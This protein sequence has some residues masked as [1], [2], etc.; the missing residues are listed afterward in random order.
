MC[1]ICYIICCKPNTFINLC[2][3]RSVSMSVCQSFLQSVC[4]LFCL[5]I[6]VF[7][8]A[9]S[10]DERFAFLVARHCALHCFVRIHFYVVAQLAK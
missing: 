7:I 8:C 6:F 5:L 9:T 4:I 10:S 1:V 3:T 2:S